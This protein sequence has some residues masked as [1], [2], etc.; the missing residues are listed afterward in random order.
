MFC[1]YSL[2]FTITQT[3]LWW[4]VFWWQSLCRD[5][6]WTCR[7]STAHSSHCSQ[8]GCQLISSSVPCPLSGGGGVAGS[9]VTSALSPASWP[10]QTPDCSQAPH[11]GRREHGVAA[12]QGRWSRWLD[13]RTCPRLTAWHWRDGVCGRCCCRP[14]LPPNGDTI[15]CI[16][17]WSHMVNT[18]YIMLF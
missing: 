10:L 1:Y 11:G 12:P 7:P 4:R 9:P 14:L 3:S 16:L 5:K 13:T 18:Q 2:T 17:I 8:W 15:W 6:S